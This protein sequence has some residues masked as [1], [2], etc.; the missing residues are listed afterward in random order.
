MKSP[1]LSVN[2]L[3]VSRD[4]RPLIRDLSLALAPG[5]LLQVEGPNGA[6]KSSL[7][8]ALAG[9]LD[10]DGGLIRINDA[11]AASERRDQVLLWTALPGVK[12]RL[13]ARTN[14]AWLLK[15]RGERGDP[16]ELLAAVGLA[17]W[18]DVPL[19]QMS[20][21]QVRRVSMAALAA[22]TK[23]LWLLDEPYNAIDAEGQSALSACIAGKLKAG[24][25]V[26]LASHHDAPGLVPDHRICLGTSPT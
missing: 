7:I 22:S 18:E 10:A 12:L 9:L 17:G 14:V 26:V 19:A 4:D 23:P 13:D 6:G 8:R 11:E 21:G 16:D 15:L 1:I 25:A 20:T 24:A 5:E 2:Q 3:C